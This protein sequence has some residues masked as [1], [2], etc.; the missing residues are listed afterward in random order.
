[1]KP[2]PPPP[3]YSYTPIRFPG[4]DSVNIQLRNIP[5]LALFR[6]ELGNPDAEPTDSELQ[7][8]ATRIS[9]S[10]KEVVFAMKYTFWSPSQQRAVTTTVGETMKFLTRHVSPWLQ[11]IQLACVWKWDVTEDSS[12]EDP[13][14]VGGNLLMCIG[15]H[16]VL[17]V[18]CATLAVA[19][20]EAAVGKEETVGEE[21]VVSK[22]GVE[23]REQAAAEEGAVCKEEPRDEEENVSNVGALDTEGGLDRDWVVGNKGVVGNE[24]DG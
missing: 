6:G 18:Q 19:G 24:V 23:S 20:K 12:D 3:G 4:H 16:R 21:G 9:H 14:E 15:G 8:L 22:E 5:I 11:V 7:G 10:P 17:G 13:G 2:P 1:M